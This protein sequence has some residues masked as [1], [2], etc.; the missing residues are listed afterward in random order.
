MSTQD[1]SESVP[2]TALNAFL[3]CSCLRGQPTAQ[4]H[5]TGGDGNLGRCHNFPGDTAAKAWGRKS[6]PSPWPPCHSLPSPAGRAA[7]PLS[8]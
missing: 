4:R 3:A 1:T 2:G 8:L 6:D 7:S 5:L